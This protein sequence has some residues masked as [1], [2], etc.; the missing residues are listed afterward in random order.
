LAVL[1]AIGQ[2]KLF[3]CL[4]V[5][6]LAGNPLKSMG[7]ESEKTI[8]GMVNHT[9]PTLTTLYCPSCFL[10]EEQFRLNNSAF[11]KKIEY[12]PLSA[13]IRI[14]AEQLGLSAKIE[15]VSIFPDNYDSDESDSDSDDRD[16]T[17][18]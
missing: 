14:Q 4:K 15:E 18:Q 12:D 1:N 10:N 7:L 16:C 9:F 5:L 8:M 3:P 13:F 6:N 17:I 11:G 2:Q